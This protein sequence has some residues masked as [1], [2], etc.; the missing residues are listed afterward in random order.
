MNI[1]RY[2]LRLKK[3]HIYNSRYNH[4]IVIYYSL[5]ITITHH[6]YD[7]TTIFAVYCTALFISMALLS[8]WLFLIVV[9]LFLSQWLFLIDVALFYCD[10]SFYHYGSFLLFWLFLIYMA[11]FDWY[12]S[13]L[14]Q[15]FG[16]VISMALFSLLWLFLSLWLFFV[17][18]LFLNVMALFYQMALFISMA[19]FYRYGSF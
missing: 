13:F 14:S 12:G 16:F 19:L 5:S 7:C 18:W 1:F 15:W 3:I 8:Q 6:R 10:A 9:S 17:L 2:W 11:L 4:H